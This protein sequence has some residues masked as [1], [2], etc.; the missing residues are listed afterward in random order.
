LTDDLA[1]KG[2]MENGKKE[3]FWPRDAYPRLAL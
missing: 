2:L 3:G 1:D